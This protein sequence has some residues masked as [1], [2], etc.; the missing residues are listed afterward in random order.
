M[1]LTTWEMTVRLL[2]ASGLGAV[3]GLERDVSRRAAGLRT[4]GIVAL[5]AALFAMVGAYGFTE[6]RVDQTFDP[7]RVAAQ[8][9][10]GVGF[11]GAGAILRHGETVH[12]V[13]TAATV[14]LAAAIGIAAG[15]GAYEAAA[16]AA[17][18]S[19]AVLVAFR[20]VKPV[21]RRL[22]PDVGDQEGD[23]SGTV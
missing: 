15:A 11:I 6:V 12:G 2:A 14:W 23:D 13:T 7:T 17:G 21:T 4:H 8:V 19:L 22:G 5:G 10:A 1:N 9:A 3:V 20:A 16:V 18:L